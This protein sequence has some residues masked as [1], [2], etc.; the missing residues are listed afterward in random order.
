VRGAVFTGHLALEEWS[1]GHSSL[2]GCDA[3]AKL[4]AALVL[5]VAVAHAPCPDWTALARLCAVVLCLAASAAA[6]ARLPFAGLLARA[7][8]VLPFSLAFA[9]AAWWSG[10]FEHAAVLAAKSYLSACLTLLLAATTTLE[11]LTGG[12]ARLRLPAFLLEVVQLLY[13]Y[14]FL[15]LAEV[16][17]MRLAA[18]ARGGQRSFLLASGTVAVLFARSY[19]RAEGVHRAMLARGYQGAPRAGRLT[20]FKAPDLAL[21]L[22]ALGGAALIYLAGGLP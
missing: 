5:L 18:A 2:H 12:L 16:Q 15:T 9:L 13:R 3:R 4:L 22:A 20:R 19:G 17:R 11:S 8:L 14:L 1:R 6:L 7:A 10:E 21:T